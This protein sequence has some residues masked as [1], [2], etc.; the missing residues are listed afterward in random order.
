MKDQDLDFLEFM[1]GYMKPFHDLKDGEWESACQEGV[2]C[3]NAEFKRDI[4]IYDGYLHYMRE[5]KCF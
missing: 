2:A 4:N 1:N 3:F 5:G